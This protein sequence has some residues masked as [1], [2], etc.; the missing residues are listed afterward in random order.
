MTNW[1]PSGDENFGLKVAS[2]Q[3]VNNLF[4]FQAQDSDLEYLFWRFEKRVALSEKKTPLVLQ[5]FQPMTGQLGHVDCI[6]IV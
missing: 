1:I 2:F 4:K 5:I 6:V 3:K